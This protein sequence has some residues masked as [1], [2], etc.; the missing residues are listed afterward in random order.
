[1]TSAT[2]NEDEARG[3][4]EAVVALFVHLFH[5]VFSPE[6]QVSEAAKPTVAPA[7]FFGWAHKFFETAYDPLPL[8]EAAKTTPEAWA[9]AVDLVNGGGAVEAMRQVWFQIVLARRPKPTR[10]LHSINVMVGLTWSDK[11]LGLMQMFISKEMISGAKPFDDAL[12][13]ALIDYNARQLVTRIAAS[14]LD[15]QYTEAAK[16]RVTGPEPEDPFEVC[17]GLLLKFIPQLK[18]ALQEPVKNYMRFAQQM[19]R[20]P[21]PASIIQQYQ[22]ELRRAEAAD[23]GRPAG[24]WNI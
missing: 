3:R 18:P 4:N 6:F 8:Q 11:T 7:I 24:G 10:E 15:A 16:T 22:A 14:G 9:T 23:A 21:I 1:M 20:P 2:G 19:I 12:A 17:M 5:D 13:T